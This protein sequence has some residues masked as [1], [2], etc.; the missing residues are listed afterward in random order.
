MRIELLSDAL[1][2]VLQVEMNQRQNPLKIPESNG[3]RLQLLTDTDY[4]DNRTQTA[5]P[6]GRRLQF[7][8]DID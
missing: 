8:L 4:S 3:H 7:V 6:I 5:V 2:S 1:T